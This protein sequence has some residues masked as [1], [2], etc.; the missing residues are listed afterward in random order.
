MFLYSCFKLFFPISFFKMQT[1]YS[2]WLVGQPIANQL[3]GLWWIVVLCSGWLVGQPIANHLAG[4]WWI[5][6]PCSGWL[7]GQPIA[8][9]LAGLW[10]VVVPCSGSQLFVNAKKSNW[11]FNIDKKKT[12]LVSAN[13]MLLYWSRK[14]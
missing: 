8:N 6:V 7:V 9:Q 13:W 14:W 1:Y 11:K 12:F 3:A 5:V 10:W 2:Y 4:L